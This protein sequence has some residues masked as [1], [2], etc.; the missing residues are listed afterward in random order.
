[1]GGVQV[2][3]GMKGRNKIKVYIITSE[4]GQLWGIMDKKLKNRINIQ[5]ITPE[6]SQP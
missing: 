3:I 6:I 1:M 2:A 4:L 5:F